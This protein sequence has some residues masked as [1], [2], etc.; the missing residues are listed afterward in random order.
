SA[1][2]MWVAN[3]A[4]VS[5]SSDTADCRV[6]FT[7]AN[8]ASHF[9][10]ALETPTTTRILRAIFNDAEKFVIHE[11][12]P[13]TAQFGDEGAANHMRF[14]AGTAT[15]GLELF[16]YGRYSLDIGAVKP[17]IYPE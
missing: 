12:L 4:T 16:V 11:P 5:P 10:R 1:A 14:A 15:P 2:A 6:H 13:A 17:T 3:A 9:H 8:L 7:P